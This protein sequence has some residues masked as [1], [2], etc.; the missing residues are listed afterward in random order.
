MFYRRFDPSFF[1]VVIFIVAIVVVVDFPGDFDCD[2]LF[3]AAALDESQEV[4]RIAGPVS[5]QVVGKTPIV[6]APRIFVDAFNMN[7]EKKDS[8]FLLND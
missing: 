5:R 6:S 8:C 3:G 4:R 7:R 2:R 1:F